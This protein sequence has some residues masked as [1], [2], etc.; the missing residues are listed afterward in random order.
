VAQTLKTSLVIDLRGNLARK[1][2][3][4][5][6]AM[7][8]FSSRGQ[9]H[10]KKL[11][12][13]VAGL[14][15]VFDRFG[16]RYTG[17]ITGAAGAATLRS[18]VNLQTRF[19]RLGIAADI[20]QDKVEALK[21]EIFKTAQADNIRVD[22][23][24][25]TEAV[26]AIVEKTGDLKFA[27]ENLENI[28]LALQATG[29]RG[30]A[31][32][33]I[34]AEF[35]K[36][37]IKKPQAVMEALDILNVQGKK[38]AFTLQNIAALG[39]R[40]ITAYTAGGRGG[41][42]SIRELGA[43]LQVIR[44]GTGSSEQA[45]TSFEALLRT[46]GDKNKIDFLKRSGID[47]FDADALKQGK[48]V[49]RPIHELVT[50]ILKKTGGKKSLLSAIFD[51][52]AMRSFNAVTSE[53]SRTGNVNSL[54]QFIQVQADGSRTIKDA[55]RAAHD[56]APALQNLLTIWQEFA[57]EKSI[58]WVEKFTDAVNAIGN[59]NVK[60]GLTA[61]SVGALGVGGLVLGKKMLGGKKSGGGLAG[62]MGGLGGFSGVP[63]PVYVVNKRYSAID[64]GDSKS[65]GATKAGKVAAG[66]SLLKKAGAVGV[67]GATG[68]G[69]GSL[70]YEHAIKGTSVDRFIG[71]VVAKTLA[72]FGNDEARMA[73]NYN[74]ANEVLGKLEIIIDSQGRPK[75]NTL[76]SKGASLSVDL[77]HT[78]VMP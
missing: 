55:A 38:G 11:S 49:L 21:K 66:M 10:I 45:A 3:Q 71:H 60:K 18:V 43:M 44:M 65:G 77:G 33:E 36:M 14:S 35:Q 74:R 32:G 19:T 34:L 39:P 20:S 68:F 50:D 37:D 17:L 27:R 58:G 15:R 28:G 13:G 7:A 4:Y 62:G 76:E 75:V 9:R 29:G 25:I 1:S 57:N 6:A 30:G 5:S 2:Q 69:V 41:V 31:I 12:A 26:E 48:E 54:Q 8:K 40:V 52:E 56:A 63:V 24:Q 72:A 64:L 16:N 73:V 61:L 78:V 42:Q 51:S 70:A 47:V 23:G 22:P 67:A 46:F 59:E 53:F